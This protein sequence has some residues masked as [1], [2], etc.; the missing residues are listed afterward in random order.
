M[1]TQTHK[2]QDHTE[3]QHWIEERDGKPG[4]VRGSDEAST[5]P[6]LAVDFPDHSQEMTVESISWEEFFTRFDAEGLVFVYKDE[7]TGGEKSNFYKVVDQDNLD[8]FD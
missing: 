8:H 7:T 3:I 4:L 6:S 2:T 5:V 1:S